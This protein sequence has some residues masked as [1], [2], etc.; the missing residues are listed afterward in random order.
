MLPRLVSSA[1]PRRPGDVPNT[2]LP[3]EYA[4]PTGVT[5]LDSPPRMFSTH[6]RSSRV[7][8]CASELT[9]TKYLKLAAPC[10]YI[11]ILL[12]C[13]CGCGTH[14]AAGCFTF[15]AAA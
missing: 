11:A 1:C 14:A 10:L 7:A 12:E 15:N 3:P 9:P 4:C 5:S 13:R 8:I 2:T 6:T